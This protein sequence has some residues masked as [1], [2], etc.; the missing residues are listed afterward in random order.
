LVLAGICG[1]L[2]G[3][4]RFVTMIANP[5][6]D[7]EKHDPVDS[8]KKFGY[9]FSAAELG[10]GGLLR[11]HPGGFEKERELTIEFRRWTRPVLDDIADKVGFISDWHEPFISAEGLQ[12]YGVSFFENYLANPQSKLLRLTKNV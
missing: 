1:A 3:G 5:E 4:G 9:Y 7:L 8:R 12:E 10:N 11:F 2:S 6:F